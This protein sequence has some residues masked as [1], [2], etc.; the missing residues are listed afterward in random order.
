VFTSLGKKPGEV[1][2]G[3]F[4][5]KVKSVNKDALVDITGSFHIILD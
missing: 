2:S 4:S 3:K 1:L 5:G